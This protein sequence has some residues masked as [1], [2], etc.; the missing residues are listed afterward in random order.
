MDDIKG[1]LDGKRVTLTLPYTVAVTACLSVT[2]GLA[3]ILPSYLD[4]AWKY[5]P[6][7]ESYTQGIIFARGILNR[8]YLL[9]YEKLYYNTWNIPIHDFAYCFKKSTYRKNISHTIVPLFVRKDI[10]FG[11]CQWVTQYYTQES[12]QLESSTCLMVL[13]C[14]FWQGHTLVLLYRTTAVIEYQMGN[15]GFS[16]VTRR[17]KGCY[18][19]LVETNR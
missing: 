2:Q 5:I 6:S 15:C 14:L 7:K 11:T 19:V 3:F 1:M 16:Y 4:K 13:H 17:H 18:A 12:F 10:L 9:L 8:L